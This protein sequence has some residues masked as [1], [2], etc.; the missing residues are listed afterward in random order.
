MKFLRKI[1]RK[2]SDEPAVFA[3]A[4]VA[5]GAVLAA[6]GLIGEFDAAALT[7]TIVGISS[8]VGALLSRFKTVPLSRVK[9]YARKGEDDAFDE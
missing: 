6:L 4:V 8:F 7:A 1:L 3:Q 5:V 9:V 2:F